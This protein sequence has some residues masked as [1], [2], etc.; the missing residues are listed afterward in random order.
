MKK[1]NANLS[2]RTLIKALGAT[3]LLA[4][5]GPVRALNK[6]DVIVVGAGLSGLNAALILESAGLKVTVLEGR[7]RIGG[8][9]QSLRNIPGNPEVGGTAFAPGKG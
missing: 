6:S 3:P 7:D 9:V 2:R 8:R 5:S 1:T 4:A